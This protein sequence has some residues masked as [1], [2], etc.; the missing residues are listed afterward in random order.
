[1]VATQHSGTGKANQYFIR[2]FNLDHGT[3]FAVH[4][5]GVPVNMRSHGHGQGYLDLNFLIPELVEALS[6]RRGPYSAQVG[7]FSSAAS[8]EFE[9]YDRLDETVLSATLGE[10]GYYRGLGAGSV[11]AGDS[12]LTGA[13]D[14][15]AYEGPWDLDEDLEQLNLELGA[16]IDRGQLESDIRMVYGLGFLDMVRYEVVEENG[17]RGIN[18]LVRQDARG[19]NYLEWGLDLFSDDVTNGFNLRLGWLKT[20]LDDLGS[21]LRIA[22]QVGRETSLVFDLYKYLDR[23]A[24]FFILPRVFGETRELTEFVDDEPVSINELEQ[25]GADIA[26]GRE[27]SRHAALTIGLRAFKGEVETLIGEPDPADGSYGA[28]EYFLDWTYD[29]LDDRY[30]PTNGIFYRLGYFGAADWLGSDD[31]YDQLQLTGYWAKSLGRHILSGGVSVNATVGG[32]AP[33]YALFSAG[34]L[35]NLSGYNF[36]ESAGQNLG[37]LTFIYQYEILGGFVPGRIG[38]SLEYGGVEDDWEDLFQQGEFHGS[39]HAGFNT[40]I[41][42]AYLGFGVGEGGQHRW[43]MKFGRIFGRNSI[44]R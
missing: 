19:T 17:R 16:P 38:A 40:P 10:Y 30:L 37:V 3:D 23:S 18:L 4:V 25:Y 22:G 14:F 33:K 2:G 6:Y 36:G 26:L 29:R 24:K 34:G 13:I 7:D 1:M 28:G 35:F 31:Q 21:E 41:G 15:T 20:D 5:E 9:L 11:D 39:V 12:V 42:P 43:F 27:F 44:I 32:I 8:V